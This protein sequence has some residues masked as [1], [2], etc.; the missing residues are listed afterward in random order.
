MEES[1]CKYCVRRDVCED[2][3]RKEEETVIDCEDF[4]EKT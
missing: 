3:S 2:L 4:I 1:I